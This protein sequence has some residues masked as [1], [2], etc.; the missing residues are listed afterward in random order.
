M[1]SQDGSAHGSMLAGARAWLKSRFGGP[2]RQRRASPGGGGALRLLAGATVLAGALLAAARLRGID[3][4]GAAAALLRPLPAVPGEAASLSAEETAA[5]IGVP[6]SALSWLA[7]QEEQQTGK[8]HS[9]E[10]ARQAQQQAQQAQQHAQQQAQQAQQ[11]LQVRVL[12]KAAA[13]RVVKAWLV[14][15][16]APEPAAPPSPPVF[17]SPVVASCAERAE[18]APPLQSVKA[19]AMGPQHNVAR[20]S[21]VGMRALVCVWGKCRHTS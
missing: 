19:E 20:L 2:A 21:G 8:Q 12:D 18:R 9:E 5:D 1:L 13:A 10:A 11:P 3:S 17:S 7:Q 15:T 6:A 14:S 4:W 16:P